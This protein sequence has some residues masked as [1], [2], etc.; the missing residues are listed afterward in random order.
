[1]TSARERLRHILAEA[2][3]YE[4]PHTP[5]SRSYSGVRVGA[6]ADFSIGGGQKCVQRHSLDWLFD[7]EKRRSGE[8]ECLL[9]RRIH[10]GAVRPMTSQT[11][12]FFVN[13]ASIG[14]T[15]ALQPIRVGAIYQHHPG[16]TIQDSFA[17]TTA[18]E[19]LCLLALVVQI[20]QLI[21]DM[22]AQ[23]IGAPIIMLIAYN[24]ASV[25]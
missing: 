10:A 5:S 1:M 6:P 18:V 21:F 9:C 17:L 22:A 15:K 8:G 12:R 23:V 19:Q 11:G 13:Y 25:R 2:T 3:M 7:A 16:I 20:H 24:N 14:Q 4:N